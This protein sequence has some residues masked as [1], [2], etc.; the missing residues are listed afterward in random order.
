MFDYLGTEEVY[1]LFV[2][3]LKITIFQKNRQLKMF[4]FFFK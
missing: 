2:D 4:F 3:T 1:K